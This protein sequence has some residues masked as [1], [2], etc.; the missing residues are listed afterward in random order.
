M[1]TGH[2]L[3]VSTTAFSLFAYLSH[4]PHQTLQYLD[5]SC[6]SYTSR[7]HAQTHPRIDPLRHDVM[8]VLRRERKSALADKSTNTIHKM[9]V[10]TD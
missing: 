7:M 4:V 10:S 6:V 8:L 5:T 1:R 9:E 2:A 3:F